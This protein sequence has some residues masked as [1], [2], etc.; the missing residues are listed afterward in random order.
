M[1]GK[2]LGVGVGL[3]LCFGAALGTAM[4]NV[5]VGTAPGICFGAA[6]GAGSAR[7]KGEDLD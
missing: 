4:D 2:Y 3:G 6:L 1:N 7:T 5:A